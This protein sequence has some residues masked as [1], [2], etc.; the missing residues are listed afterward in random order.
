MFTR[1]SLLLR[2]LALVIV[3]YTLLRG[4]FLFCNRRLFRD[5]GIDQ[6]GLAFL[7]GL[8]FDLSVIVAINFLFIFL[9]FLPR[10]VPAP[11]AY[12]RLLK[13]VFLVL[14]LV[15]HFNNGMLDNTLYHKVVA[16]DVSRR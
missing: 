4:L 10:R 5:I 1:R 6:I 13:W 12:E 14:A 2:R 3:L 11:I 15:Q 9:T 8:R 16:A 7:Q